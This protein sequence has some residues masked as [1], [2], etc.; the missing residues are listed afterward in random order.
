MKITH[1]ITGLGQGGA[2]TVLFRLLG[3]LDRAEFENEVISLTAGGALADKIRALGIPVRELGLRPSRPDPL[4]FF[5]LAAWLR[6][7]RPDAVQT[8]M[9]HADLL[10]GLAA[11]LA[12]VPAVFWNIR[13][14][15]L[16]PVRDKPATIRVARLC[17]RFSRW[18]PRRI[19]VCSLAAVRQ[20]ARLGYDSARMIHIPNGI[21]TQQF[22][23]DP[24][25][26]IAVRQELDLPQS[27]A[28]VGMAARFHPQKD[29]HNFIQ[30]AGIVLAAQPDARFLLFG[31]GVNPE[32]GL[33]AAWIEQAG[34]SGKIYLLG[35][36]E[37]APRL[38]AALDISVLSSASGEA[39]PNVVAESMAC[40]VPAAATDI[41]DSAEI[42]G[43]TG[44]V[45]PPQDP[46]ALA[47]AVLDLL[48]LPAGERQALGAAARRRVEEN[49]SLE[50]MAAA[51]AGLYQKSANLATKGEL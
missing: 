9:Y 51:Y 21:D 26:R 32:N 45:V 47:D 10:G 5:R 50:R 37:D 46:S 25:A 18:L 17:A 49:F 15:T 14:S 27:A 40:A 7:S 19:V 8:W 33:L 4:K 42:I 35:P 6:Q 3:A 44:R 20:H 41:G 38:F 24:A 16:D 11:R 36:R 23:P 30:A 22:R 1:I 2:E 39:F 34:L 48:R 12:R 29:H 43:G 13:H 31:S 28:L